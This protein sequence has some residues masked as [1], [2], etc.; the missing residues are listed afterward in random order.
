MV[1]CHKGRK[2]V[3]KLLL[4]NSDIDLNVEDYAG[5]TAL[6]IASQRGHQDIVQLLNHK[7]QVKFTAE[8]QHFFFNFFVITVLAV[9]IFSVFEQ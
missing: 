3:V 4:D 1:A 2:D 5:R 6:T 7:A 8:V 9:L